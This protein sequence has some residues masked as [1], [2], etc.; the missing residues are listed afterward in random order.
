MRN[1]MK[2]KVINVVKY[3]IVLGG[4]LYIMEYVVCAGVSS[5]RTRC[6]CMHVRHI[7][8]WAARRYSA[9]GNAVMP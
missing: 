3:T 9:S 2:I 1:V 5:L 4:V 6:T 8:R 7:V